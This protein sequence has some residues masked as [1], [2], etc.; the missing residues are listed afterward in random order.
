[1]SVPT[2]TFAT[3]SKPGLTLRAFRDA[4]LDALTA[5][6]ASHDVLRTGPGNTVPHWNKVA[7]GIKG[8]TNSATFFAVVDLDG[9]A[10]GNVELH[11]GQNKN[12][13]GGLAIVLHESI[14]G[15]G[16]GTEIVRWVVDYAFLQLGLH[17]VSLSV[18]GDNPRALALYNK[19][20]FVE[21]GRKRK[22]IWQDG[23]WVD[24]IDMGILYDEWLAARQSRQ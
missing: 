14:R 2:P 3:L 20:G 18:M 11:G 6:I 16:H 17:R 15:K 19:V 13:D 5:T 12:R 21:E 9:Q 24:M 1:M 7:E 10:V 22:G 4:D 23:D 8:V